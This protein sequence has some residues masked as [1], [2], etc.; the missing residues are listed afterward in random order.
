MIKTIGISGLCTNSSIPM[1][2]FPHKR[3]QNEVTHTD[4]DDFPI[5][6]ITG[7]LL[8]RDCKGNDFY[9]V[10]NWKQYND[11]RYYLEFSVQWRLSGP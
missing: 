7:C 1:S 9:S 10:K 2:V 8:Q 6:F 5:F 4:M 3:G 11:K